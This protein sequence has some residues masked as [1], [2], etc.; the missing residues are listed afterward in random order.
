MKARGRSHSAGLALLELGSVEEADRAFERAEG[1]LSLAHDVQFGALTHHWRGLAALSEHRFEVAKVFFAEAR[2]RLLALG[3]EVYAASV[4]CFE[5][6]ANLFEKGDPAEAARVLEASV[7]LLRVNRDVYRLTL[8]L[9]LLAVA[10]FAC[11]ETEGARVAIEEASSRAE[12]ARHPA[13]RLFVELAK[14]SGEA[15]R[16]RTAA[17]QGQPAAARRALEA[18][19]KVLADVRFLSSDGDTTV[20]LASDA[21]LMHALL[22]KDCVELRRMM[23]LPSLTPSVRVDVL[24]VPHDVAFF[25]LEGV[26][27]ELARRRPLRLLLVRLL[28]AREEA[29]GR[30]LSTGELVAAGWP[31]ERMLAAAGA[32]RLHVAIATLRKLGLGHRIARVDGGYLVLPHLAIEWLDDEGP[33]RI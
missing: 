28:A 10:R 26:R 32:H 11:G 30:G 22:D 12:A 14:G 15:A 21:R 17:A 24:R 23:A 13:T 1:E 18:A 29:A 25:E 27:V 8:G 33:M 19:T 7:A 4:A 6:L 16:A 31:G 20:A 5:A 3:D 2:A 9:C